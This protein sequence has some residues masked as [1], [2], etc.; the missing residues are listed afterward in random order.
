M[1]RQRKN[2]FL[3][4]IFLRNNANLILCKNVIAYYSLDGIT[5]IIL[6]SILYDQ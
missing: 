4:H 6:S 2:D 3:E 1:H 5:M